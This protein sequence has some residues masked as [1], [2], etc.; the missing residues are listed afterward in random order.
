MPTHVLFECAAGLALFKVEQVESI[1][2]Q[3]KQVQDA[4]DDLPSFGKMVKLVSF[5][6]FKSAPEALQGALDISEGVVN[7]HLRALL[8]QNLCPDGKKVKGVELGVCDR[9][10]ASSIVGETGIPCDTGETTQELVRGVR[11]HADKLLKGM[12]PGDLERAQLGLCLLYTSPSP[13]DRG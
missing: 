4:I 12:M 8:T 5:S 1:G 2:S 11:Q 3:T 6:P 13:R 9:S 10:L 7:D